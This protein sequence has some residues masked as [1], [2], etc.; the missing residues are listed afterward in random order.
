MDA[1]LARRLVDSR[2]P[3]WSDLPIRSITSG[4]TDNAV[5]RL[6]DDLALRIPITPAAAQ[7]LAKEH[8]WLPVVG[9]HLPLTVPQP[10]ER[11]APTDDMP[12]EWSVYRWVPGEVATA[13]R[14]ADRMDLADRLGG[15]VSVLHGLDATGGPGPGI[16]NSGRGVPLAERDEATRSA[17]SRLEGEVDTAAVEAAWERALAAPVWDEPGVWIHGDLWETNLLVDDTGRLSA[18]ID[19]GCLGVGDPATDLSVAW[20]VFGGASRDR[21][22]ERCGVDEAMWE[23]GRGWALSFAVVAL[24]YYLETNPVIVDNA[25]R[26]IAAVIDG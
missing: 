10:V 7:R 12:F 18:V 8:R 1:D 11:G 25:R 13:G 3:Q 24:P 9:P 2:F 6:G 5:F 20:S 26:I 21:F 22:R 23:R 16:H 17:Q 14:I 4:G 15:F 19:F